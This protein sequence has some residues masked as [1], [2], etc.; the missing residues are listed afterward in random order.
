MSTKLVVKLNDTIKECLK[1]GQKELLVAAKAIKALAQ[2][3][4]LKD[5]RK[6]LK[7]S[8]I[9][10]SATKSKKEAV[11]SMDIYRVIDTPIA[12]DNFYRANNLFTMA[13]KFLPKQLTE[14]EVVRYVAES[15]A[16]TGA[17]SM[18]EMGKV[19]GHFTSKHPKGTFDGKM[20]SNQIKSKLN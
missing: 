20:V 16:A 15:I 10:E 19:M 11:E 5:K 4:A 14:D 18:K 2:D 3:I 13:E 8:D 7:D 17:T 6:E 12:N 1:N 9:I